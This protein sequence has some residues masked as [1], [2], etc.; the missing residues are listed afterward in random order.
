ML[1]TY[2]AQRIGS[3][4]LNSADQTSYMLD[5]SNTAVPTHFLLHQ[6]YCVPPLSGHPN[7]TPVS[8]RV[9]LNTSSAT[10]SVH[11]AEFQAGPGSPAPVVVKPCVQGWDASASGSQLF[12]FDTVTR[13]ISPYWSSLLNN[14]DGSSPSS[15]TLPAPSASNGMSS[16]SGNSNMAPATLLFSPT[17]LAS[18]TTVAFTSPGLDEGDTDSVGSTPSNMQIEKLLATDDAGSGAGVAEANT[19]S[20][21]P[22][23]P[24]NPASAPAPAPS[25]VPTPDDPTAPCS[26]GD[27]TC[28]GDQFAECASAAWVLTTCG[29]GTVCRI[30]PEWGSSGTG[31]IPTCDTP[32]DAALRNGGDPSR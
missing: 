2:P 28:I 29:P 10:P 32:E 1:S 3:L 6:E 20:E 4:A 9:P 31:V 13:Q 7:Y 26:E 14:T 5:V 12:V 25:T 19:N 23:P 16:R 22:S 8:L 27:V 15:S 24:P 17:S 11:C 18:A 21:P 30:V